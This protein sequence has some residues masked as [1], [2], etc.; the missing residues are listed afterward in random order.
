MSTPDAYAADFEDGEAPLSHA[1]APR[2]GVGNVRQPSDGAVCPTCGYGIEPPR[3]NQLVRVAK[4]AIQ[5]AIGLAGDERPTQP[6]AL[7]D[8]R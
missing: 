2:G 7:F 3:P 4:G 6:V 1:P 5:R 8:L